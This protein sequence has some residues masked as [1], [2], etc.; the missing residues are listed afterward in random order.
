[1][2][3]RGGV[4]TRVARWFDEALKRAGHEPAAWDLVPLLASA[5]RAGV[6]AADMTERELAIELCAHLEDTLNEELQS[7]EP[8][9]AH[10]GDAERARG[11]WVRLAEINTF[12]SALVFEAHGAM[13]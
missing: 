1:M 10:P 9:P 4:S 2:R 13:T 6:V 7:L 11:I 3:A 5:K 8:G 12:A